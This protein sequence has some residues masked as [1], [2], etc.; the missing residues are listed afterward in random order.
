MKQMATVDEYL[1]A[2]PEGDRAALERVRKII[3]AAAPEAVE[4]ISYQMPT[5]KYHG[6]LVGFAAFKNHLS[7][8]AMGKTAMHAF[9]K[10][11]ESYD[12]TKGS[13]HFTADRPLPA[14]LIKK[15]VKKRIEENLQSSP[16]AGRK[17]PRRKPRHPMPDYVKSALRERGLTEAYNQR[18]P[19][20]R[21]DYIGWITQAKQEATRRKRLEQM[22]DELERGDVYMKMAYK[23]RKKAAR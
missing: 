17:P 21:N 11:L 6:P 3:K 19:Y 16:M 1:E 13:I 4:T 9:S 15:I 20:Q 7:F 14:A 18:P 5:F 12:T 2:L 22:L 8:F 23:P 10:E